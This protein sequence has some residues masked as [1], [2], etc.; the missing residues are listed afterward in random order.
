MSTITK[1]APVEV[2]APPAARQHLAYLDG[3]RALAALYVVFSHAS[4]THLRD[5]AFTGPAKILG[6]LLVH[7]HS[8]V[9]LFIVLSG[10]CL[11]LPVVRG[12]GSLQGG[13]L[14]FF[15]K[16]A[17]RI[18]PPY[19]CC[20]AVTLLLNW[21]LIGHKTGGYWDV[22]VPVT[23]QG[24]L[25]HLLLVQDLFQATV[26]NISH[27]L[28]SISVEWRIYFAFPVLVLIWRKIGPLRTTS[29]AVAVS[30]LLLFVLGYLP[31]NL[32]TPGASP[33]YLGL[34]VMGMLAAEISFSPQRHLSLL[35]QR[36]PWMLITFLLF[37]LVVA[38]SKSAAL[39]TPVADSVVG[40]WAMTLL[41]AAS[42]DRR[43]LLHRSL[44]W[45]PLVFIGTFAYSLYLIHA[46]LLQILWQYVLFPM[47]LSELTTLLLLCFFG[48]PIIIGLSYLFFLAFERPFLNSR[49]LSAATEAVAGNLPA[50]A[51]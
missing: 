16:R 31:I 15:K 6:S 45:R 25:A 26:S 27:P 12:D 41:V 42:P 46:P 11:M 19:F 29:L 3:L 50:A 35:R 36:F 44:S 38:V 28:W 18:L 14:A 40:L 21:L 49:R 24:V 30:Y 13:A 4:F 48:T 20:L 9:N 5:Q 32:D 43:S 10:F 2:S 34:F 51:H 37:L 33:Q 7:G 22:S 23:S 1:A 8:A 39:P 17:R 47:H